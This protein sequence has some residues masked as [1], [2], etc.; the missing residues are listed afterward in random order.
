M[1]FT[2]ESGFAEN[3]F[4]N[5]KTSVLKAGDYGGNFCVDKDG[6]LVSVDPVCMSPILVVM[7]NL[8]LRMMGS[9]SLVESSFLHVRMPDRKSLEGENIKSFQMMFLIQS[10]VCLYTSASKQSVLVP[11]PLN[12]CV[13]VADLWGRS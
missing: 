7:F 11:P 5:C 9:T 4:G 13:C 10:I 3:K 2:G 1:H 8:K 6:Y 12:K